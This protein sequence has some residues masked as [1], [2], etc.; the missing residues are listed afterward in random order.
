MH[1]VPAKFAFCTCALSKTQ[2][3]RHM[4]SDTSPLYQS[5]RAICSGWRRTKILSK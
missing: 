1:V 3:I 4:R 2:A 5:E